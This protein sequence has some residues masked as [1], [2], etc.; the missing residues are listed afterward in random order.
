MLIAG[1]ARVRRE[2]VALVVVTGAFVPE[3]VHA[4]VQGAPIAH[5]SVVV[6]GGEESA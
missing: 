1:M 3:S 4:R 2:F 5:A 6:S